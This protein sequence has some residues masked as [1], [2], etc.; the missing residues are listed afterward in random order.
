MSGRK[1]GV[2]GGSGIYS[3]MSAG[4][5]EVALVLSCIIKNQCQ[6]SSSGSVADYCREGEEA[7]ST[8]ESKA[9]KE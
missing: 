2:W 3:S 5:K 1:G 7:T 8:E 6:K 4:A 9:K